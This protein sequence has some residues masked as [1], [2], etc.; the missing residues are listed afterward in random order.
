MSDTQPSASTRGTDHTNAHRLKISG[1]SALALIVVTGITLFIL[2]LTGVIWSSGNVNFRMDNST[3]SEALGGT[4]SGGVSD[5]TLNAFRAKVVAIYLSEDIA[6]GQDEN[7]GNTSM[8]YLNPQC[9]G[10]ISSCDVTDQSI[11]GPA[12]ENI[13]TDMFNLADPEFQIPKQ[14]RSVDTGTYKY[15]RFEFCKWTNSDTLANRSCQADS[16]TAWEYVNNHCVSTYEFSEPLNI[17]AGD[18]VDLDVGFVADSIMSV[19]GSGDS[20]SQAAIGSPSE[21]VC[22]QFPT[23]TYVLKING[24]VVRTGTLSKF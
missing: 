10:D 19:G 2:Y 14:S 9:N 24:S 1:Y 23:M 18:A 6:E 4:P 7:T 12:A 21:V 16:V 17:A 11:G 15:L 20:C 5:H 22:C 13:V 8:I 3:I